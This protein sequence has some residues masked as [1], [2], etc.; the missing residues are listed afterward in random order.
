MIMLIWIVTMPLTITAMFLMIL[1]MTKTII[2]RGK[3]KYC[4]FCNSILYCVITL[5]NWF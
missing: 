4:N 2:Y 3:K 5:D 1:L